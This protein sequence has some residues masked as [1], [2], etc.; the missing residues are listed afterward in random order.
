MQNIPRSRKLSFE[1]DTEEQSL[2]DFVLSL[3]KPGDE[4]SALLARAVAEELTERQALMVVMYYID[5]RSMRDI[6]AELGVCPSTV[7]RT[8]R[9][10]REKL[11]RCLRC[12]KGLLERSEAGAAFR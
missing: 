1:R 10:A 9:A 12:C 7:C 11:R 5:R 4:I 3:N 2:R 8:L 6:A